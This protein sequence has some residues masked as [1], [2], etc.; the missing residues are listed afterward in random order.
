[1]MPNLPTEKAHMNRSSFACA[2]GLA[3]MIFGSS[4]QAQPAPDSGSGSGSG[5]GTAVV[6]RAFAKRSAATGESPPSLFPNRPGKHNSL[7]R[8]RGETA[9]DFAI[10]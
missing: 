1:M 3:V 2:I 9:G 7:P 4:L 8:E 10:K 5:A 6:R